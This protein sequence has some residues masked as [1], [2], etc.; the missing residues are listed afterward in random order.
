MRLD[1]VGRVRLG[2][3]AQLGLHLAGRGD[4]AVL[5]GLESAVGHDVGADPGSS[6]NDDAHV[7]VVHHIVIDHVSTNETAGSSAGNV[8]GS[9][10]DAIDDVTEFHFV[11]SYYGRSC[12]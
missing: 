7:L 12:L 5:D 6:A 8:D 2:L 11:T 1:S 3:A 4:G 9:V 10:D